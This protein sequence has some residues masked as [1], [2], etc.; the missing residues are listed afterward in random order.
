VP[1]LAV[2]GAG[3]GQVE[4]T[5]AQLTDGPWC[6]GADAAK[7]PNRF[8]A[9]LFRVRR[10]KVTMRVQA[11]VA[12]LRGPAG[13]LFAHAGTSNGGAKIAPDQ[14]ITFSVTPRNMTLGR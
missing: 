4:L 13:V 8:D 9:D 10:V 2:L 1:R 14:E 3:Q 5:Q 12:A 6:P 11:A 7:Y